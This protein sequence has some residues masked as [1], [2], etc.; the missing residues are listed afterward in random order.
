[1]KRSMRR[2]RPGFLGTS[3]AILAGARLAGCSDGP[4]PEPQARAARSAPAAAESQAYTT[5]RS[6][7]GGG[8]A[9]Q[10][11]ALDQID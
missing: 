5:W 4:D 7:S 10:Y 3:L 1:M 11:S 2:L 9:S 8:H 6:Y